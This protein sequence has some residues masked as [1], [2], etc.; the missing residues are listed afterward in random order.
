MVD[1]FKWILKF[2]Y[3]WATIH[4]IVLS[5]VW[6]VL[7]HILV[8]LRN[9]GVVYLYYYLPFDCQQY[10]GPACG[11]EL[12]IL[13]PRYLLLVDKYYIHSLLE[14]VDYCGLEEFV[15]IEQGLAWATPGGVNVDDD[16][17]LIVFVEELEEV[18]FVSDHNVDLGFLW[19]HRLPLFIIIL[20]F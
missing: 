3:N 12:F 11:R 5:Y 2:E 17:L 7:P 8:E 13:E 4:I 20:S 14:L 1:V 19:G 10:L 9:V 15:C 18:L 6:D 16:Q